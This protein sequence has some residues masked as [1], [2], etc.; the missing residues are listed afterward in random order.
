MPGAERFVVIDP[1]SAEADENDRL[2]RVI[3][4]R[5]S[6]GAVVSAVVLSHHHRDHVG[7]AAAI[8]DTLGVPV[9]AHP[10]RS[11]AC[12]D[13]RASPPA[14]LRRRRFDLG[15]MRLEVLHT[16][17]TRPV[18]MFF[19]RERRAPRGDLSVPPPSSSDSRTDMERTWRRARLPRAAHGVRLAR[20][21]LPASAAT[22]AHREDRE[23]RRRAG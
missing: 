11:R 15:R 14:R 12:R 9:L 17:G 3:S 2:L 4:R 22:I 19:D 8:A 21:P 18:T 20:P 16:R 7:G 13:C 23:T 1:G 6:A 10:R 5:V